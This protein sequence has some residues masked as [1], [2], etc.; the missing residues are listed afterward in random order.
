LGDEVQLVT[1]FVDRG[2]QAS[3]RFPVAMIEMN[4][5]GRMNQSFLSTGRCHDI[6]L[7]VRSVNYKE[8]DG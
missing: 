1:P 7:G 2:S 3:Q 4:V 8:R 5:R 6:V